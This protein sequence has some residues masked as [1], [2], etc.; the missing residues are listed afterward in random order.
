MTMTHESRDLAS[1]LDE[2]VSLHRRLIE[3]EQEKI[4][5]V[6]DQKWTQLDGQVEK[7]RRLLERIEETE[8]LRQEVI[9]GMGGNEEMTLSELSRQVPA[10]I[11]NRLLDRG[12]TLRILLVE[13]KNLSLQCR[14]IVSS[15]LEVVDFTLSLFD[16]T[17][18]KGRMYGDDGGEQNSEREQPSLVFDMK[19]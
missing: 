13:L 8:R 18:S 1:L 7:S 12:K 15:S 6:V 3:V 9:A 11:G 14:Q 10:E 16:G 2:L 4:A 17:G 5:I 19:A